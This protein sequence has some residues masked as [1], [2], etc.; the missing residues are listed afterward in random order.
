MVLPF[1]FYYLQFYYLHSVSRIC[2]Q[3]HQNLQSCLEQWFSSSLSLKLEPV[4]LTGGKWCAIPFVFGGGSNSR[5]VLD[6]RSKCAWPF[7]T[8]EKLKLRPQQTNGWTYFLHKGTRHNNP[9]SEMISC[10]WCSTRDHR[11]SHQ[12]FCSSSWA[13]QA[14]DD[15]TNKMYHLFC[16][17]S[18]QKGRKNSKTT[19]AHLKKNFIWDQKVQYLLWSKT[20]G[21]QNHGISIWFICFWGECYLKRRPLIARKDIQ[22]TGHWSHLAE[23]IFGL[24][25]QTNLLG[26]CN[27]SIRVLGIIMIWVILWLIRHP[28][29]AFVSIPSQKQT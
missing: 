7:A 4:S 9:I 15:E 14:H 16:V 2:D 21:C 12:G 28:V 5:L 20:G 25:N 23:H 1:C 10:H 6:I 29:L 24:R 18:Q 19:Q 13:K 26:C 11:P 8:N 3:P 22:V 17:E 27:T